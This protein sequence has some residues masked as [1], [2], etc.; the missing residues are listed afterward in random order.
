MKRALTGAVVALLI[1][2]VLVGGAAAQ[3]GSDIREPDIVVDQ[4]E[5][6]DS[7]VSTSSEN[8]T[9]IYEVRGEAF[10]IYFESASQENITS[11]QI[12][13]GEG[14]L[15]YD[16]VRD[17]YRFEPA[18]NGTMTLAWQ[19]A[20]EDENATATVYQATFRISDVNWAHQTESEFGGLQEDAESWRN[21]EQEIR[22]EFPDRSTEDVVSAALTKEVFFAS[23]F[24]SFF[25]DIQA[26]VIT[27]VLTPGGLFVLGVLLFAFLGTS[28]TALRGWNALQK[29]TRDE[30]RLEREKFEVQQDKTERILQRIDLGE[31]FPDDTAHA[32]RDHL[33]E[34]S[35]LASKRLMTLWAPRSVKGTILQLMGQR[36]YVGYARVDDSGAVVETWVQQADSD[37]IPALP[38]T[39]DDTEIDFD[40]REVSLTG[41]DARDEWDASFIDAVPGSALDTSIFDDHEQLDLT[42]VHL[43][44]N[45]DGIEEG[46][47]IDDLEPRFP[48]DFED[49]QHMAECFAELFRVVESHPHYIDHDGTPREEMDLLSFMSEMSTI[50]GDEADFPPA[51]TYRR[52]FVAVADEL[53]SG[54]KLSESIDDLE[55]DGVMG[56][57]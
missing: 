47:L 8:G 5:Y 29:R 26:A 51:Q 33:G 35:W 43:P 49:E 54:R 27:L 18:T 11:W 20:P 24:A 45:P 37:D 13:E 36:G 39:I 4:P 55:R 21:V 15:Q 56:G 40:L 44:I 14:T 31:R 34:N 7:S 38:G 57:D 9:T 2:G 12:T 50:I 42:R 23:P 53:T 16:S 25:A 46:A 41:L 52:L 10:D 6:V 48:E 17:R 3:S 1:F 22:S 28:Y 19:V 30:E 32:I